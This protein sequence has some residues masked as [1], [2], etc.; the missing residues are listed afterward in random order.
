MPS[1][2]PAYAILRTKV[3]RAANLQTVGRHNERLIPVFGADPD[4]E[5]GV[6]ILRMDGAEAYHAVAA[7]IHESGARWPGKG[8]ICAFE[9]VLTFS[10]EADPMPTMEL[11]AERGVAFADK[12]WGRKNVVAAWQHNDERTPHLHLLAVPICECIA[13]GRPC[14]DEEEPEKV[15]AVSWRQFSGSAE[16]DY[17]DPEKEKKPKNRIRKQPKNKVKTRQNRVMADWQTA[18]AAVWADYGLR[19]G[20]KSKRGHL[21]MKLIHEQ[22]GVIAGQ[23][24]AA[25]AGIADAADT[26]ELTNLDLLKLRKNPTPETVSELIGK[27]VLPEVAAYLETLKQMAAKAIQLGSEKKARADLADAYEALQKRFDALSAAGPS[28]QPG[29]KELLVENANLRDELERM[30]TAFESPDSQALLEQVGHLSNV[31]FDRLAEAR[32]ASRRQAPG[33]IQTLGGLLKI[34]TPEPKAKEP[35]GPLPQA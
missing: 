9:V 25:M 31:E 22:L 7:R 2:T 1:S 12:M 30:T 10:N 15:L 20:I 13:P 19:R 21:P 34:P 24:E 16:V 6:K 32:K 14:D 5:D 11:L 23:A 33:K 29:N 35:S 4:V 28:G 18:W 27:Y 3:Q 26:L 17:R 8:R